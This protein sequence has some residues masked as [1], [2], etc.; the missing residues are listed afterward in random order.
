MNLEAIV[1]CFANLDNSFYML[2]MSTT[3]SVDRWHGLPSLVQ[4][5]LLHPLD[6]FNHAKASLICLFLNWI[7]KCFYKTSSGRFSRSHL[8]VVRVKRA[9]R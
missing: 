8:A 6:L 9:R 3:P 2:D 7:G 5:D 4:R 1:V